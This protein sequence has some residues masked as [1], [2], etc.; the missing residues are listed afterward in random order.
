MG[1]LTVN[2]SRSEFDCPCEYPKCSRT[3]VDF[4]LITTIQRLADHFLQSCSSDV[5]RIS[6]TINSGVRCLQYD[7][8]MKSMTP[9]DFNDIK[10]SEHVWGIAADI[11]FEM[12]FKD[13]SRELIN[14][15]LVYETLDS[16]FPYSC[17]IGQ[18]IGRTHFDTRP[19]KAR[20]DNRT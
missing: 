16:W 19:E 7:A 4:M 12:V 11:K 2:L 10:V 3:P 15:D 8:E 18:Y 17:G 14:P 13:G 20:W 1:D 5:E 9:A 6:V